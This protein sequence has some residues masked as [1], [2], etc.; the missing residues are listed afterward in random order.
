MST[1]ATD[2]LRRHG[3]R[4][5]PARRTVVECLSESPASRALA[6]LDAAF[7]GDRITLYRTLKSFEEVGLIHRVPDATGQPRYAL[8]GEGCT[9][10]AHVHQH[11][12]FQCDDCGQTYCLPEVATVTP[13]L[14]QGY[15]LA[16]VHITYQGS[17]VACVSP[18]ASA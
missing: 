17:C 3:L 2:L 8:C 11:P 4:S 6:E 5:T 12:H 14:P 7:D 16:Q 9:P 18:S 13:V 15:Q 10:K 1:L